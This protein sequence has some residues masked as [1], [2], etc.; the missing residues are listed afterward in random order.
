MPGQE[1]IKSADY[2]LFILDSEVGELP[3]DTALRALL[4]SGRYL[5]VWNKWDLRSI[6]EPKSSSGTGVPA[7]GLQHEVSSGIGVPISA[8]TGWNLEHLEEVLADALIGENSA[9][10]THETAAVTHVRHHHAL[11]KAGGQVADA[12]ITLDSGLPSDFVS[13]DIRC[14]LQ[15]LGEITGETATEDIIN[16][17]FSRF[18]IGK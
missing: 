9:L 3:E 8:T 16:E 10:S 6:D 11:S 18:C 15:S 1:R 12:L 4:P 14:V 17:I 2:V 7:C 5:T 13:I